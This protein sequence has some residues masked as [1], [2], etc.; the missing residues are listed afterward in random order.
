MVPS[1]DYQRY[2]TVDSVDYHHIIDPETLYPAR[3]WCSVTLICQ[4]SG[5]ADALS[6]ALFVLPLEAGLA[7]L[8][9]CGASAMWVDLEGNFHYSPGFED[10]IRT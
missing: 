2:Y 4:D 5:L 1:G 8:A 7:L 6:T 9:Q 10:S 3:H